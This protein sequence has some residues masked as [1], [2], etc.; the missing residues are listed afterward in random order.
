MLSATSASRGA[1]RMPLPTRSPIRTASTPAQDDTTR[2]NG[3]A[4][5]E[6]A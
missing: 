2:R 4:T 6:I 3:L 1:V 5:V